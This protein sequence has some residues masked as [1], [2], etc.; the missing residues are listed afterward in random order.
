[1]RE[2]ATK[3]FERA[4]PKAAV[5]Q[6]RVGLGFAA[7]LA[8]A[9]LAV[10]FLGIFA[11]DLGE[12]PLW[13]A[14]LT[15]LVQAWLSTG[16]FIVAHDAMH[17]SL[18]PAM[19]RLQRFAGRAALM[20]YAGLDYRAM[21]P[22]HFEHHKHVGSAGDPD[23]H[24]ENPHRFWPWLLRFFGSY[25]THAQLAR[26]T[27]VACVYL[28]LGAHL[29]NIVVFWAVPA[30]AALLQLFFFGTYLPHRHGRGAF[31]DRHNARSTPLPRW[32]SLV[33]CFHFGG[34]HHEHHLYPNTP[35]W[36][37]PGKRAERPS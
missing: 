28:L 9:W 26:I 3:P 18:A 23:F 13:L 7:L 30:L 32:L 25:Y 31:A 8:A 10:H 35:W 2:H 33:T 6:S 22:K 34:Y 16:L 27:V 20:I 5:R 36:A 24:A 21:E 19:P 14:V 1:M 37:L 17:G 11:F 4:S 15:V 29:L 12:D